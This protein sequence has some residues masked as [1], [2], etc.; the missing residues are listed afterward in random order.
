MSDLD[1]EFERAA[2]DVKSLPKRPS[3]DE[4][5]KLYGL[6]KQATVGDASGERPGILAVEARAKFDAWAKLKG[7][8]ADDAKQGYAKLVA[9]LKQQQGA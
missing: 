8:E 4:L 6:F 2:A 5:L 7:L 1:A 3:N 9:K